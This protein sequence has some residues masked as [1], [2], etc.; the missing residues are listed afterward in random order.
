MPWVVL[1]FKGD[2]LINE[3]GE[4]FGKFI[5]ITDAP[6]KKPGLYVANVLAESDDEMEK[7]FK[8]M[9]EKGK[10]G[11][12]V[13]EGYMI[14]NR[15]KYFRSLLTQ[16][17]SLKIPIITLSQKPVYVDRFV[18]SEADFHQ[19]FFLSD[20]RDED[21]AREFAPYKRM[22]GFTTKEL[23]EFYS[24]YHDVKKR[25]VNILSPVPD[26]GTILALFKERAG[27]RRFFL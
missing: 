4:E 3:I 1:N 24:F 8:L 14:K 12:Y 20:D 10:I 16:G 18:F 6:P 5:D 22:T 26:R 23:P 9:W 15:S 25:S 17:R 7:F 27:T 21:V 11:L 2:E 13:D 19:I